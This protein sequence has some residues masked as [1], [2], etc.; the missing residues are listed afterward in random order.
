VVSRWRTARERAAADLEDHEVASP[1]KLLERHELQQLL[2]RLVGELDEPFRS[3]ILLRFAE[4]LTPTQIAR[5]LA[6][7]AGTVRWRLKEALDRL[8]ARLD[9]LHRGDRRT[10]ML[11]FAPLAIPRPA[12]A[13]PVVPALLLL[14][15]AGTMVV[16]VTRGSSATAPPP[17]RRHA[18]QSLAQRPAA[19]TSAA[20]SWYAQPGVPPRALRGRVILPDG[21][22]AARAVVRLIAAPL[23]ARELTSDEH[24]RFDFGEQAAREYSL[25]ASLPGKLAA[26]RHVDLRDPGLA[27]VELVLGD[28]GAGLYGSVTDASGTPIQGAQLL[29]EGVVG[30]ETDASGSYELCALPTAALVAELRV[31]VRADGFGTLVVP[32]APVGRMHRDFV[33]A[34]ES[35]ISGRVL[36]ADGSPVST[37][38]VTISLTAPEASVAPERGVSISALTESDG[39]F[40][41]GGLAANAYTV[42]ASSERAVAAGVHVELESAETRNVEL[43]MSRTGVLRGRVVFQGRPVAAVAV[44]S[45]ALA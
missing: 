17:T 13:T 27:D 43:R 45:P 18:T 5:R 36:D 6:I 40:R 42:V 10:W 2:A 44:A 21:T 32:M 16:V 39:T 26:I 35:S 28:C 41:V 15:L 8:R 11:A 23:A 14:L 25:G 7:P 22:P 37:A 3:T 34:P 24:G 31:V 19:L 30:T 20:L 9:A 33:L 38:R 1:E 12:A 29:R 4:G